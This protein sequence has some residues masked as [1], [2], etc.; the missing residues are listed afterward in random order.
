MRIGSGFYYGPGQTED[1]LQPEANDRI[2]KTISS[3]S[4]LAYPLDTNQIFANYNI[5]DPNLGFQ[6]RAYGIGYR[7]PER[8]LQYTAS[9]QQEL[10]GN[11]VLTVAYV[12]SQGRNLFL[13]SI[14]NKIVSVGM[15]PTTG[16]AI[17]NREFGNR[18]AEI[19]YKTSGGRD[20]Y[21]S[22]QATLNRRY[23][24]GLSLGAQYTWGHSIGNSGGSNEANTA[25]NPYDF[26]AD[27]GSNNFDVRQS[28][29]LSALYE[30]PFGKGKKYLANAPA[31]ADAILGGWQ[32]GGVVNAR[33]GVPV[34]ILITRPD[35]V[36]RDNRDGKIYANPVLVGSTVETTPIINTPGGGNSRNVRRPDVVPGVDPYLSG[37]LGLINPAAFAIPLPGTFGNSARNS[38]SGPSLG[39]LDLTLGKKFPI[40]NAPT[41]NSRRRFTTS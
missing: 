9:V 26:N 18:F 6:P 15:N 4:L 17:V 2:G 36:Y 7:I 3:G 1:Q 12:G 38:L 28:F 24:A 22:M 13:R 41:S 20:H 34:D 11:T 21:D 35:V 30:M 23:K 33:T 16:A 29:N 39:Q 40:R 25:G 10:P 31:F 19:D 14:T 8:I 27:H 32:L 5:N 37:G